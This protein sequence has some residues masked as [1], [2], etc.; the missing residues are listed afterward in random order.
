MCY[1][2]IGDV[3]FSL[4]EEQ[5]RWLHKN[6]FKTPFW[7]S[8]GTSKDVVEVWKEYSGS[9]RD[10]LD[11]DID[12]LV[13][14]VSDIPFQHSLGETNL[15]AKGKMAFKFAN[16]FVK[17][18]IIDITWNVGGSGRVTPIAHFKPI[19]LLGSNISKASLYN[20]SYISQIGADIGAEILVC[21]ANEVIPRVEKVVKSTGKV[22]KH[23]IKCPECSTLLETEGE[24]LICPNSQVCPAQ[25][26][27]KIENWID[28]LNLLEW[29][30]TLL[31]RLTDGKL[32]ESIPDLYRLKVEDL[33]SIDRMGEKSAQKCYDILWANTEIPLEV[34]LGSL[35]IPMI[36]SSMIK[37]VVNAGYDSLDK[38]Q[39]LSISQLE[40][41]SGLGPAKAKSLY[42]GLIDNKEIIQGLLNL[43]ISIKQKRLGKLSGKS[44]VIT[45]S[46]SMKRSEMEKLIEDSGGLVKSSVNKDTSYLIIADTSSTSSKAVNAR[47]L[48]ISLIDEEGFKQLLLPSN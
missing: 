4:E 33:S 28:G 24:Y 41:I 1:Q 47:K 44:F 13:V 32:V 43:G 42:Q 26:L 46:F 36:G 2:V 29:G 27:G 22:A 38:I 40:A 19:N 18:E 30:S 17:T 37:L 31:K 8:C 5:F 45:G 7:K 21:K 34:F 39:S 35:S 10:Q 25:I 15:R 16:Q 20:T 12:G 3:D 14:A 23:P 11:Y 9:K 6:G 48:G